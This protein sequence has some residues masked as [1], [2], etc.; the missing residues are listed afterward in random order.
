MVCGIIG[1]VLFNVILGPLAIIFG[2]VGLSKANHGAGHRGMAIAG[3]VLGI[4]DLVVL[5]VLIIAARHN[6]GT[7]Y[8]HAG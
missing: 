1:L 8:F 7:I 4:A 5:V 3:I 2:A 6:G